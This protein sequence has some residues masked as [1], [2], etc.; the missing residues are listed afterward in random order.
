MISEINLDALNQ[1]HT[2]KKYD[3]TLTVA[4]YSYTVPFGV[5]E[6]GKDYKYKSLLEKPI[7]KHFILSGIYCLSKKAC[8]LSTK[9]YFDMP[10]LID[11]ASKLGYKIGIF[12]IYE[13]WND[14]GT[15]KALILEKNRLKN[16]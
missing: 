2:E 9:K 13:Y 5:V 10:E 12:P 16:K 15:P 1:F 6:F 7:K 3:I 8:S 4:H 14:I 11:Q